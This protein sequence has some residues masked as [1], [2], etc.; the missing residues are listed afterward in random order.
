MSINDPIIPFYHE[1]HKTW[2]LLRGRETF[3]DKD[4]Y[5]REWETKEEAVEWAKA[6]FPYNEIKEN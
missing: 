4:R 5:L 2:R 6:N 1:K 3:Y